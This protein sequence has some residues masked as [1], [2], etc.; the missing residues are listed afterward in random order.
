MWWT[1]SFLPAV[2]LLSELTVVRVQTAP[3]Q[4]CRKLTD[5]FIK[6]LHNLHICFKTSQPFH[7]LVAFLF[8][9]LHF[10]IIKCC[11]EIYIYFFIYI[12]FYIMYYFSMPSLFVP[13]VH[14]FYF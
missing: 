11:V 4:T 9:S 14:L 6:V 10:A 2:V 7:N 13:F 12:F 1:W 5:S 8:K 3:C